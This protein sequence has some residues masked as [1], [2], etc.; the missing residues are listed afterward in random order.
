M[1]AAPR[2]N[3]PPQSDKSANMP[4]KSDKKHPCPDCKMCQHCA[5]TRCRLCKGWLVNRK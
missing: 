1:T 5:D 4:D 3:K 2:R